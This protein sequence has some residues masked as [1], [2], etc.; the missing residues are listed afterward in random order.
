MRSRIAAGAMRMLAMVLLALVFLPNAPRADEAAYEIFRPIAPRPATD[1]AAALQAAGV[2][3]E[4]KGLDSLSADKRAALAA[5][6]AASAAPSMATAVGLL[7]HFNTFA[8]DENNDFRLALIGAAKPLFLMADAARYELVLATN[9]RIQGQE[10][11]R[12]KERGI[13]VSL[14]V[15]STG[16]RFAQWQQWVA[17]GRPTDKTWDFIDPN[18]GAKTSFL[19]MPADAAFL[20]AKLFRSDDDVTNWATKAM[21]L[22]DPS[23]NESL[24]GARAA[25]V[26]TAITAEILAQYPDAFRDAALV[27]RMAVSPDEMKV[28]FLSPTQ[29]VRIMASKLERT[30]RGWGTP[31]ELSEKVHF[32]GEW[33][34]SDLEKYNGL[35]S[36][37]QLHAWGMKAGY[38]TEDV[39]NPLA[40][41]SSK[42]YAESATSGAL[43]PITGADVFPQGVKDPFGWMATNYRQIFVT[44]KGDLESVAKYTERMIDWWTN[45]NLS[46]AELR[47]IGGEVPGYADIAGD[48]DALKALAKAIR[49]ADSDAAKVAAIERA[50]GGDAALARLK[51]LNEMMMFAGQRKHLQQAGEALTKILQA[52]VAGRPAEDRSLKPLTLEDILDRA[53]EARNSGAGADEPHRA[54]ETVIDAFASGYANLP[55]DLAKVMAADIAGFVEADLARAEGAGLISAEIRMAV[56]PALIEGATRARAVGTSM[57]AD[58]MGLASFAKLAKSDLGR[59]IS[60]HL[61]ALNQPDLNGYLLSLQRG[62]IRR[63]MAL[64]L[65]G[66]VDGR[67]WPG[68]EMV[69]IISR[70]A[71]VGRDLKRIMWLGQTLGWSE[72]NMA[73]RMAAYFNG[74]DYLQPLAPGEEGTASRSFA[75]TAMEA[76]LAF[77]RMFDRARGAVYVVPYIDAD[78]VERQVQIAG[79]QFADAEI[80]MGFIVFQQTM[81]GAETATRLWGIKGDIESL[82]KFSTTLHS[83]AVGPA[84]MDHAARAKALATLAAEAY[85]G[86]TGLAEKFASDEWQKTLERHIG[87]DSLILGKAGGTITAMLQTADDVMQTPEAQQ[88]VF[89]AMVKDLLILWNPHVATLMA[90][91]SMY[92]AG[93][94][95]IVNK[96]AKQDF[97]DLLAKNGEWDFPADGSPPVL[98]SIQVYGQRYSDDARARA[99]Q[100]TRRALGSVAPK[101]ATFAP[102][103]IEPVV[104]IPPPAY[105]DGTPLCKRDASGTCTLDPARMVQPRADILTLFQASPQAGS[106]V[107]LRAVSDSITNIVGW[108]YFDV[109]RRFLMWD[110]GTK[111]TA[112]RLASQGIYPATP[113]DATAIVQTG[114]R[115]DEPGADAARDAD[116]SWV[117]SVPFVKLVRGSRMLLGHSS[118]EYWVRRQYLIECVM[119]DPLIREAG[120]IAQKD[121]FTSVTAPEIRD[122][123]AELD[124]RIRALDAKV[125]PLIAPS[126]DPY[127]VDEGA[128]EPAA[129]AKLAIYAHYLEATANPRR[130]LK[131]VEDWFKGGSSLTKVPYEVL[132]RHY[133][134]ESFLGAG[135]VFNAPGDLPGMAEAGPDAQ[136]AEIAA[137]LT[138]RATAMLSRIADAVAK[139]EDGFGGAIGRIAGMRKYVGAGDGYDPLPAHLALLPVD[140]FKPPAGGYGPVAEHLFAGGDWVDP[141]LGD[142]A[143][144]DALLSAINPL[145]TGLAGDG[146]L[147]VALK[148]WEDGYRE[149]QAAARD[150]LAAV[151]DGFRTSLAQDLG[152]WDLQADIEDKNPFAGVFAI[153]AE[154]LAKAHPLWKRL[155]RQHF[156][157][158][159]IDHAAAHS[160]RIT[161]AEAATIAAAFR[162]DGGTVAPD[163]AGGDFGAVLAL[164]GGFRLAGERLIRRSANL[165]DVDLKLDD[166]RPPVVGDA[167]RAL[168]AAKPFAGP[169]DPVIT[170]EE[171]RDWSDRNYWELVRNPDFSAEIPSPLPPDAAS[172]GAISD[173]AAAL[174]LAG[175]VADRPD[176]DWEAAVWFQPE[177]TGAGNT[178]AWPLTV[179]GEFVLRVTMTA[180]GGVPLA[181]KDIP[182]AVA[183]AE[184]RGMLELDGGPIDPGRG[185][186]LRGFVDGRPSERPEFALTGD[187]P[188]RTQLCGALSAALADLSGVV[189]A[190]VPPDQAADRIT[191]K[192]AYL[193]VANAPASAI[194]LSEDAK[195][196]MVSRGVFVLKEPLKLT[197][198]R[199]HDV[200]VVVEVRDVTG[201]ELPGADSHILYRDARLPGPGPVQL[202]LKEGD[203]LRAEATLDLP[204]GRAE[205]RSEL[206]EFTREADMAGIGL[207]VE[208]PVYATGRLAISGTFQLSEADLAET[209]GVGGGFLSANILAGST[210]AV[211]GETFSLRNPGPVL[212]ANG[213]ALDG[214]LHGSDAMQSLLVP[215]YAGLAALPRGGDL[216]ITVPLRRF[217]TPEV[218]LVAEIADWAGRPVDPAG[219]KVTLD[220]DN[221]GH[222]DGAFRGGLRFSGMAER[223][224]LAAE[225]A[226]ADGTKISRLAELTIDVIGDARAPVPPPPVEL[227]LPV[228][229][230]GS[231]RV[232][233]RIEGGTGSIDVEVAP[234]GGAGDPWTVLPGEQFV[235]DLSFPVR[236]GQKIVVRVRAT[237][238]DG[239]PMIASASGRAPVVA[240]GVPTILNLGRIDLKAKDG[241]LEVPNLIGMEAEAAVR[242]FGKLFSINVVRPK[243]ADDPAEAGRIFVQVPPAHTDAKPSR[244][245][246]GGV[247]TLGAYRKDA[248]V[249]V[250]DVTGWEGGAAQAELLKL[251]IVGVL[252]EGR[253]AEDGEVAGHV[254]RHVPP[255]GAL[256]DPGAQKVTLFVLREAEEEVPVVTDPAPVIPDPPEA[257]AILGSYGGTIRA[258]RIIAVSRVPDMPLNV[259]CSA[260][261]PCAD[262]LVET[263]DRLARQ[264]LADL[265]NEAEDDS[266]SILPD[267]AGAMDGAMDAIGIAIMLGIGIYG[268][269]VMDLAF[270]GVEAGLILREA[271][272]GRLSLDLPGVDADAKAVLAEMNVQRS[273]DGGAKF[274]LL[275]YRAPGQAAEAP[276]VSIEGAMEPDGDVVRFSLRVWTDAPE[277]RFDIN[278]AGDFVAVD[279][280]PE[281]DLEG[282]FAGLKA[283]MEAPPARVASRLKPLQALMEELSAAED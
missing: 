282:E 63:Q 196:E 256:I 33:I 126:A 263:V 110:D 102:L 279:Q 227:R 244:M 68:I 90:V 278:F 38:V 135:F 217:T 139:Y 23:A 274:S 142:S 51:G 198:P 255:A 163:W 229:L 235:F 81:R 266:G 214:L 98:K 200:P 85:G 92:S 232:T 259:D 75:D 14:R 190:P 136:R 185:E 202:T 132:A 161:E 189:P 53:A 171:V 146:S 60:G 101:G 247:L 148:D 194:V 157:V 253:A 216:S 48:F 172:G 2:L 222:R 67:G 124:A 262:R 252:S 149:A 220:G 151:L 249:V 150:D 231:L 84:D 86:F 234:D 11:R 283:M 100:C 140:S 46:E 45:V 106:D 230:P 109:A 210:Q 153:D 237:G 250:P 35:Y 154:S 54:F 65:P 261:G 13:A 66:G 246:K 267:I 273:D 236:P 82:W 162:V 121:S 59:A 271:P 225:M 129:E 127:P 21:R 4:G 223:K 71:D 218:E 147:G 197:L 138:L 242:D 165:F 12:G 192:A 77:V 58:A 164:Q 9:K 111:W 116:S 258:T 182:L 31:I 27:G 177:P 143:P 206:H 123:L 207:P 25:R 243:S 41:G 277:G 17:A 133:A 270:D 215:A 29:A 137:K 248:R 26:F 114:V 89:G 16:K 245:A 52:D 55:E 3:D 19:G 264:A 6:D 174:V 79:S 228:Y 166:P 193:P 180:K 167:A 83:L 49:N 211:S 188:F 238:G 208:L 47:A 281:L 64:L 108:E 18:S 159:K 74:P 191:V 122:R 265:E 158:A 169:D 131:A 76:Y 7:G 203:P 115:L 260:F 42:S 212:L 178:M 78:G 173:A 112:A 209:G 268:V 155:L 118:A 91:H 10:K 183:P 104:K 179:P 8:K 72:Q 34:L 195:V 119:L 22:A 32:L 269:A 175:C 221:L 69:D 61:A 57:Q 257:T 240:T 73:R 199:I 5:L 233:G 144:E 130:D 97:V 275:N 80:N 50:G 28:E 141:G 254:A 272:D 145:E 186:I 226:L 120:R 93:Q 170:A 99:E 201:A 37:E 187:G 251:G 95:Y 117:H 239:A 1:W 219:L 44:H 204:G 96:G 181:R 20:D 107:V 87:K 176:R 105:S 160:A 70:P 94:A 156:Q 30:S 36:E 213:L 15:G 125:W 24:N 62:G 280:P 128:P 134:T 241:P 152:Y 43:Q 224:A 56:L 39:A 40:A 276:P 168:L 88:A 103:G 184:L 205:G 113:E